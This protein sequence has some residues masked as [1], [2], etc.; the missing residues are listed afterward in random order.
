MI[1]E[2]TPTRL[3]DVLIPKKIQILR[4]LKFNFC[5]T[6]I[7]PVRTGNDKLIGTDLPAVTRHKFVTPVQA[8]EWRIPRHFTI[9]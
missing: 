9:G 1:E 5:K 8:S 2:C 7:T 6:N 3:S 4:I